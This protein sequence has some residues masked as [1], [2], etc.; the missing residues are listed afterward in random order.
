MSLIIL[1]IAHTSQFRMNIDKKERERKRER[2]KDC[3]FQPLDAKNEEDCV[4]FLCT[5]SHLWII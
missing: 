3:V 2:K 5:L 1:R 4:S